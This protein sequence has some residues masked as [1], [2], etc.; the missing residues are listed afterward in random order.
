MAPGCEDNVREQ[1]DR[2]RAEFLH[3]S[4]IHCSM[5]GVDLVAIK[6]IL[7]KEGLRGWKVNMP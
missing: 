5:A 4:C 3:H 1:S 2:W 7:N 6:P